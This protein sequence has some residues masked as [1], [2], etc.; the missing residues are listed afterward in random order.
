M[1]YVYEIKLFPCLEH[2]G[3]S[4]FTLKTVRPFLDYESLYDL[5]LNYLPFL[6]HYLPPLSVG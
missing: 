4:P 3:V 2:Y 5:N 6:I 1:K